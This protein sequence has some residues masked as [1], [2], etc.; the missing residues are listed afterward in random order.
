MSTQIQP[1]LLP[2]DI[3]DATFKSES[4]KLKELFNDPYIDVEGF[5]EQQE[6]KH[7]HCSNISAV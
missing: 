2:E 7:Q 5:I 3:T 1:E 6:I 4:E